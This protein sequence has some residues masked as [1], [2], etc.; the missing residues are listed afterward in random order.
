MEHKNKWDVASDDVA[1]K[2]LVELLGI[3]P[4]QPLELVI[5]IQ[6]FSY[7]NNEACSLATLQLLERIKTDCIV[8]HR[9]CT[10]KL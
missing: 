10:G 1:V 9:R 7:D 8:F 4:K 5:F 3:Q 2:Y 6:V